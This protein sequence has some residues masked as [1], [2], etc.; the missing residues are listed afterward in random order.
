MRLRASLVRMQEHVS[1]LRARVEGAGIERAFFVCSTP[2]TG[3]TMLGNMLAETGLVGRAGEYFGEVFR[4]KVVPGL[5]RKGFDDYLVECL[6]HARGTGAF[7]VKLHWDQVEVFLHLLRLRRGLGGSTDRQVIE[8]VFPRPS[9]IFLTRGDALAQAVSWWK[10]IS[11]GKWTDGRP[12]TGE[13]EF[14]FAGVEG[15]LRRIEE[16]NGA[17]RRWFSANDVEPLELSY[18]ELAVDPTEAVRAVLTHIGIDVP[19]NLTV[20]PLTE[21]Q[22]D[23]VNED[24]IRRYRELAAAVPLT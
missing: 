24:W 12:V 3:S 10:A 8:A 17:W 1:T 5:N 22:S 4:Q 19:L 23:A 9:Y 6:Q 15:R 18:E 14:D 20:E 21:R 7:G 2:R 13:A 11:S 16:H